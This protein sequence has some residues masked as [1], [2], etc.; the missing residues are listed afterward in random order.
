MVGQMTLEEKV[1]LTG[2]VSANS[3]CSGIIPPISRLGF[4]GLCLSDAGNGLR[5][6]NFVDSWP[7]GI[8]VGARYVMRDSSKGHEHQY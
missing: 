1:N 2:G 5:S 6:T 3:I 8:S 7:S 4:P